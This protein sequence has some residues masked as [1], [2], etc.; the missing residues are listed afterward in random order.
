MSSRDCGG[1]GEGGYGGG[2]RLGKVLESVSQ[3]RKGRG[4]AGAEGCRWLPGVTLGQSLP[5]LGL[6]CLFLKHEAWPEVAEAPLAFDA[7][8]VRCAYNL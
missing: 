7:T 3:C 8:S 6:Q 2:Q 5:L 1:G 4:W